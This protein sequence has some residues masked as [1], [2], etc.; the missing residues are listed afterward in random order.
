[1]KKAGGSS[2]QKRIIVALDTADLIQA[3]K[4]VCS[5]KDVITIFKIGTELFTAHG[6]KAVETIKSLGGEVFLDLKYHDIPN[7]VAQSA[8]QAVRLGVFMFNV[9]IPGGLQMMQEACVAA[10]DEARKLKIP[11]PKL[12]GVTLLTSLSQEEVAKQIGIPKPLVD[13]VLHYAELAQ[14]AGLDGVIASAR[15]IEKIRARFG[16]KFLIVTPGI[17]PVWAERGD[18]E[19]VMTPREALRLGADY[20]VIGRPITQA[21]EPREAASRIFEEL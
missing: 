4:L 18:Q 14:K 1:M 20:L 21:D 13:V 6:P 5:L 12:I 3:K 9:H 16:P 7:T 19:R 17:R 15:E 11:T 10:A 2:F 8:R